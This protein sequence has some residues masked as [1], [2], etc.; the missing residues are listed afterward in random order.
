MNIAPHPILLLKHI[1]LCAI[2][3]VAG[4]L[5]AVA[6]GGSFFSFPALLGVGLPPVNANAT[7]TVALWPGQLTSIVGFRRELGAMRH[8]LAPTIIC[9]IIGGV[10]G[11]ETL[12]H[13]EQKTFMALVP[14]LLLFGT[15]MFTL[16]GVT[17]R[18]LSRM[19]ERHFAAPARGVSF[20]FVLSLT[21]VCF[22]IGYFGAGAGF[23]IV[24]VL[25]VLSPAKTIHEM[26]AVKAVANLFANGV[27][28]ATFIFA[29][30][31]Y[32]REGLLM[33]VFAAAGGYLG[34][35][36]SRRLDARYVR[37][38]VIVGGFAVSAY[39]FGKV[40]FR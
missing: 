21:V 8:L 35:H 36:Y 34:A 25:S 11:A 20:P 24:S 39:F 14:W 37:L 28:V 10:A 22:Y 32:W 9:G 26:N 23:L 27:A 30:A 16:S 4:T 17:K 7:N 40:Y 12:L 5:N 19:S 3:M 1:Q 33:M 38:L 6:G 31:I 13:T 2:A 29:N 18:W 15:V